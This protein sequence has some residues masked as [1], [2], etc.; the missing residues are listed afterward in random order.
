MAAQSVATLTAMKGVRVLVADSQ[1]LFAQSL[2]RALEREVGLAVVDASPQSGQAA[3]QAAAVL[4]PQLALLDLW[5]EGVAAP[6]AAQ[7]ITGKSPE[8][9]VVVMGWF[10]SPE[11]M[12]QAFA[13]GAVGFVSK[14]LSTVELVDALRRVVAGEATVADPDPGMTE[15]ARTW[16]STP[17][18]NDGAG[19]TSLTP[20]ELEVLR[21]LGAGF[22]VEDVA[23]RLGITRQTA[24]TH[25]NRVI[26]KTG[27]HSQ[28]QAIAIA[29]IRGF[30]T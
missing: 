15:Q 18:R 7:S 22:P 10:H 29:R 3:A 11:H 25:L 4:R 27:A 13:A 1:R 8:T 21:L 23:C 6:G 30:L 20:R 19:K 9:R 2:A 12:R 24:R 14:G 17:D 5:L 16:M 26:S 28:L